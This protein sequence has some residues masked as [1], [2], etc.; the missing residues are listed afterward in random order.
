MTYHWNRWRNEDG[1]AFISEDPARDG[2]NWYGYCNNNPLTYTDPLGLY[3]YNNLNEA[4]EDYYTNYATDADRKQMH[5]FGLIDQA[6]MGNKSA[7]NTLNYA[8]YQANKEMLKDLGDASGN[9]S[10]VFLAIGLP[11]VSTVLGGIDT[12]S[13]L[14][15]GADKVINGYK[16][17]DSKMRTEGWLEIASSTSEFVASEVIIKGITNKV[18]SSINV[19]IGKNGRYYELG[20]RGALKSKKAI[21]KLVKKDIAEGYFGQNIAPELASQIVDKA[22]EAA[23]VVSGVKEKLSIGERI[24]PQLRKGG[25]DAEKK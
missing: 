15:I 20:R 11:E 3:P 9:A 13:D 6:S 10:L 2:A 24:F 12:V 5:F 7:Q 18:S 16:N 21:Q 4:M 22:G 14:I 8:F 19:T 1:S 17:N 23:L 25:K